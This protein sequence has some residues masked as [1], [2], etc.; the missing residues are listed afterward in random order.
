MTSERRFN[1]QEVAQILERASVAQDAARGG[2]LPSSDGLTIAHLKDLAA[3]V[4]IAPEFIQGAVREVRS[5]L[6]A[7][8]Q[9]TRFLGLP[10]G[11]ART[12]Y[13]ERRITDEE[14]EELV[15]LLRT[16]FRANGRVRVDGGFRQWT[17][18]NL[19]VLLEPTREGQRLRMSTRRGEATALLGAGAIMAAFGAITATVAPLISGAMS[20]QSALGFVGWGLAMMAWA[21]LRLP[22]WAR[23]RA[24]QMQDVAARLNEVTTQDATSA[25]V[26]LLSEP[27]S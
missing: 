17:N 4:G 6:T 15:G 10:I 16:T 22:A 1:D 23:E 25:D 18:G 8:V 24:E 26:P 14:W 19:Q 11:V 9:R 13:L 21:G 12:T 7:P 2:T 5:G 27:R 3:E 20:Q